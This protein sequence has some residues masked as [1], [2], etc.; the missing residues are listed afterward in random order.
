MIEQL[1]PLWCKS[2]ERLSWWKV[3]VLSVCKVIGAS[4]CTTWQDTRIH[5]TDVIMG[6]MASQ[7]TGV[8]IVYP[9]V[10]LCVDQRKHQSSASLA[11]VRGIHRWPVNSPYKRPVTRKM[12]P[13][14]DVIMQ[15]IDLVCQEFITWRLSHKLSR[16]QSGNEHMLEVQPLTHNQHKHFSERPL[17]PL[18]PTEVSWTH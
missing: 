14:D 9:K 18:L 15:T 13:F 16:S 2:A 11:F 1:I 5:Y 7:I 3:S 10:C 8:S 6:V 12:F 4:P 17:R